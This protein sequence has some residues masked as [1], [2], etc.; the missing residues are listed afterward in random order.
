MSA[1][2]RL[3]AAASGVG[4]RPFVYNASPQSLG[5]ARTA[6]RNVRA[7]TGR[8][9]VL[10]CGES[11]TAGVGAGLPPGVT[12]ADR[13]YA[14]PD[15]LAKWLN[16]LDPALPVRTD[17]VFG[18]QGFSTNG[19]FTSNPK[20]TGTNWTSTT[21]LNS[22]GGSPFKNSTDTSPLVYNPGTTFD[23]IEI[24]YWK[25]P[26]GVDDLTVDIGGGTLATLTG[27]GAAAYASAT[28]N[29]T[30]GQNTVNI[31][32]AGGAA[33]AAVFKIRC[34]DSTDPRVEVYNAG[35]GGTLSSFWATS[36]N[37][38]AP[39][40]DPIHAI[41]TAAPDLF[42]FD[43]G[44]NDVNNGTAIAT[45]RANVQAVITAAKVSADVI[46]LS[47]N[48]TSAGDLTAQNQ[49]LKELAIANGCVFMDLF[50]RWGGS[51]ASFAALGFNYD[52]YTHPN[53]LGYDNKAE[54]IARTIL[55]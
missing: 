33:Q 49:V 52:T 18:I 5:R 53:T 2:S 34:Y 17:S 32:R 51:T 13:Q 31:R 25:S 21:G 24:F 4:R 19:Y 30:R 28:V 10:C 48:P 35:V 23:R 39:G 22:M 12:T 42:I 11:T 37:G 44:I 16:Q 50:N 55:S 9:K 43:D 46:L 20:I 14:Y 40:C 6:L 36:S 54:W 3:V 7:R 45:Y 1:H 47:P 27:A 41:Q 38:N 26:S 29:C 8:A 15:L